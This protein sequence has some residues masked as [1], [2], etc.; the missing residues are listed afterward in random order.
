MKVTLA[1]AILTAAP[2]IV[3]NGAIEMLPLV[4]DET[5]NDLSK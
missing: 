3:V 5:I 1:L 2:R 4:T